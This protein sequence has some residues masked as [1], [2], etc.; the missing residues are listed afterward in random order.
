[1][2]ILNAIAS[3]FLKNYFD[4]N[5]I[6]QK[7]ARI[8]FWIICS[9]ALLIVPIYTTLSFR[10]GWPLNRKILL[11]FLNGLLLLTLGILY[12]GRFIAAA[13]LFLILCLLSLWT[14][15]FLDLNAANYI[16]RLSSLLL[17]ITIL[18]FIPLIVVRMRHTIV[19]YFAINMVLLV[20]FLNRVWVVASIPTS[21]IATYFIDIMIAFFMSGVVSYQLFTVNRLSLERAKEAEDEIRKSEE[22]FRGMVEESPQFTIIVNQDGTL[23]FPN[24][25][26][27]PPFGYRKEDIP[28]IERLWETAYPDEGYRRLIKAEFGIIMHEAA[29]GNPV[30]SIETKVMSSDGSLCDAMIRY[31][32][33]GRSGRGL[34]LFDDITN[35]KIIE[36]SLQASERRYR[37]LYDSMMDGFVSLDMEGRI[38]EFNTAYIKMT[39]HTAAE[40]YAMT[41][42]DLT[43]HRFHD[44]QKKIIREQVLTR[45]HSETFEKEY[46]RKDGSI[47]PVELRI[48]LI[49]NEEG[50]NTGTWSI[51]HDITKRKQTEHELLRTSKIESLGVFAGGIAHDFN[52][53]LTAIMGNI[54][55]AK[56]DLPRNSKNRDILNE[57]EKASERAKDLTMQLLTFSK[58]GAPIK[59]IASIRDLLVD[60]VEFVLRGSQIK[61][62]FSIPEKLWNA[63]IDVGQISQVIHN[64]ALNAREAMPGGGLVSVAAENRTISAK[65]NLPIESGK[66]ISIRISDTGYGIPKKH[67]HKIFDPF[68]TTKDKGTGLG[69][70][71]T[72]SIIKKHSGHIAVESTERHGTAFTILLPATEENIAVV[73]DRTNAPPLNTGRVLIMDDEEMVL[74]V[75][76]KILNRLGFATETAHDG[77]EAIEL[78]RRA[79]LSGK[80]FD[81][82]I[83]DLTVPGGM[84]GKEAIKMLKEFD[85]E[86]KAIVSSGYSNDPVMASYRDYGFSGVVAKPYTV[87]DLQA[88]ITGLHN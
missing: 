45:G 69:L 42:W 12:T 52:N 26:K 77:K 76:Q 68:F 27:E 59:K 20:I 67:L 39:G 3:F 73:A 80:K 63:E 65:D 85:P 37:K 29:E 4:K 13:H 10:Y 16:D 75:G 17:L 83:M 48:Y 1:M 30:N 24:S 50:E 51:V 62:T 84:G 15:I 18:N 54:S 22:L 47:V 43:P 14:F 56:L 70:S 49:Q 35:R 23:E 9:I 28:T 61:T 41:I 72:Y 40:L 88:V 81:F 11:L 60:T 86:I 2:E 8:L 7:K 71:V 66:F 53:L 74:V 6:I 5:I 32:P 57:A 82:V 87:D 25:A 78:Y 21:T 19:G 58:G 38:L 79:K 34:M 64:L 44:L 46:I 55:I 36:R 31:A 33:L